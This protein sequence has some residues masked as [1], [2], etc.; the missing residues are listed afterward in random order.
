MPR[1]VPGPVVGVALL[2]AVSVGNS[3]AHGQSAWYEGFE[4]PQTTW[5]DAGGDG[6]YR[7]DLHKRLRG[8]AHTGDGCERLRLT[9]GG[10]T[11]V[12]LSHDVGRPRVIEE[13]LPT[14]WIKSDRPGLQILAQVV[15]PRTLDPHTG[16]PT[17]TLVRGTRYTETGRWQ[18]LRIDDI[19]QHLA[20][21]VRVLRTQLGS[22]VDPREAYT[23][24]ILLNVYGGPGVTNVWIDDLDIA[25]F[26]GQPAGGA[27]PSDPAV[28]GR[29]SNGSLSRPLAGPS[30]DS[31]RGGADRSGAGRVE[32]V[33]STLLVDGAPIFPRVIQ[34]QGEPLERLK[35]LGFNAVWLERPALA[36]LSAEADRLGLWL[37]CPPPDGPGPTATDGP[38]A[39]TAQIGPQFDPVLAW[40]LGREQLPAIRR[41]A[42][43]VRSA[44]RSGGRPLICRPDSEL[45]R[46]SRHVQ[47]L[48]I[49][50]APLG[51]SLELTDYCRWL[52][53]R[54]RLARPGTPIWSTVQTQPEASLHWQWTVSGR[55]QSPPPELQ[56]EQ[57]RLLAY[58][59]LAAG[60]RGLLFESQSPLDATDPAS[61]SRATALELLNLE[62][63]LIHPW[64]AT[65]RFVATVRGSRP[66]VT[67][68]LLRTDRAR[69]LVPVCCGPGAQ[70]VL[71]Q[72]AGGSISF[73][74][75]G[76]PE[77]NKVYELTPTGLRPLHHKRVTGGVLVTLDEF[78]LSSLVLLTQDPLV[79]SSLSRQVAAI[80]RR[81]AELHRQ[82]AAWKLQL[83]QQINQRL[84]G[85]VA[86]RQSTAL[87]AA[88]RKC[89]QSCDGALAARD[90]QAACLD[91]D[92][93]MR[94]LRIL[95]RTSW[96][97]AIGSL[98]SPVASPAALCFST[99]PW[100]WHLVDEIDRSRA[101][102]NRLPGG[103][104]EDLPAMQAAGW[105]HLA[106]RSS[107][108]RSEA[109]LAPAAARS[110]R[111]GLRLVA[112]AAQGET[113]PSLLETPPMRITSP[114]VAVEAATLL[115]IHGWV[116]V[117]TPITGSVDGL[118]IFDSLGGEALA[119]RIGE[120]TGWRPFTLYRVAPRSGQM[121]VTF[122]L[123]G[124]GEVWLD[125]VTIQPLEPRAAPGITLLSP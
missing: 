59:A 62:L 8:E 26:V 95:E 21:G 41:R 117:P 48:L 2:V 53:E 35:E 71:G 57:I 19:S 90:Y 17:S 25:G 23:E 87:L 1:S 115:R 14:L 108:V 18:Q 42:G 61:R 83:A 51:T 78:S 81:A 6:P 28:D 100:H 114:A 29:H 79:I 34:H 38:A 67:G 49:G 54:P 3:V 93:A 32:L 44:D 109:E 125:D 92:R 13:F 91:A 30:V 43:Q 111:F 40:D 24:R 70:F 50:R 45:R 122:V 36:A 106:S 112:R 63:T 75:A 103:D 80:G 82:L 33:G 47:L 37:V 15:L 99:L 7:I 31:G 69:L 60:S 11:H 84:P 20:R 55:G 10:G 116:Q 101:G 86:Q 74:V 89:L 66:D 56:G 97:T 85:R 110:G 22:G 102:P 119:E 16:E 124:L 76:V 46:C 12:H 68:V 39:Q 77:S 98:S 73:R 65:G 107:A 94:P 121:T 120:T 88:A 27:K 5:R 9:A 118:L 113:P 58:L 72:S 96:Q 123:S 104:F 64:L 4:G 105:H 52:R